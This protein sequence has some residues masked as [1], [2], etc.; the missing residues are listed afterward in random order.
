MKLQDLPDLSAAEAKIV[1]ALKAEEIVTLPT[2]TVE[3]YAVLLN[4]TLAIQ[5]LI[6]LKDRDFDSG[7]I[8]TMVPESPE[9]ISKYALI[10]PA[11]QPLIEQY[12]PGELTLI[13]PKNP[14]FHHFYYD[15]FEKRGQK[16]GIGL[17]IPNHPLFTK[18]LPFTG[19][20]ILTSANPRGGTPVSTTGHLPSTII[21]FTSTT[22]KIL[23]QGNLEITLN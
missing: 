5:N 18:I 17:R 22:P 1:A 23:R 19:P 12:F 6:A 9:A 21:D 7:K 16:I 14:A 20:L 3:G 15:E 4:S 2:E 11:A 13:L 10:P 8:F